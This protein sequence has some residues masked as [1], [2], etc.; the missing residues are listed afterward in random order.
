MKKSIFY[1]IAVAALA[2]SFGSCTKMKDVGVLNTGNYNDTSGPLKAASPFPI[3]FAVYNSAFQSNNMY[4]NTVIREASSIT[5]ENELKYGSVVQNNGS[6]NFTN[7][8]A[9]VNA[10]TTAGLQVFGHVLGWHEQQ[11]GTYLK[12]FAG[13]T[14]PAAT[15][16]ITNGGFENGLS[17]WS[18]FNTGNPAG[19]ATITTGSGSSEIRTGN[20]SMKVINPTAYPGSQ[21]RVQVSSASFATTVGKQ[22][23][24]SY[25]V[26]AQSPNGSIRISTGPTNAQ[27]QG[28]QTIGTNWQNVNFTFTAQIASTTFL[29]D[30]G[31][32]ANT[33][34][35]D[36][37][38]VKE[39]VQAPSG[40]NIATKLDEAL[41]NWITAA[42]TRYKGKIKAWDVVNELFAESGAVRN[43]S[44]TS[45]SANTNVLVWSNYLGRDYAL[46]AFNYAAAADPSA[47]L[48]IND[49]N[50]ES[51]RTKLDSLIAYVKEMKARGAKIDGIGTQMHM[52]VNT[53]YVDID[54]MFQKLAATGLLV[55]ISELDIRV[56]PGD[57]TGYQLI[58]TTAGIQADMYNYVI[59]SY[60]KNVPAAQRHGVTI[61]GVDDPT[62]WIVQSQK[63]VDYPLLFDANFNKKAAYSGVLR[64]LKNN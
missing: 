62:S 28:D 40:A 21:W 56:N 59:N 60:Y 14:V 13:I 33:Y 29:F 35:I 7:A 55:R 6:F 8:D 45:S 27:Y 47:L 36:D 30:M 51:N 52:S 4:R 15:E 61:W 17:G 53:R 1:I 38:S 39:V 37:V 20:G 42:V 26:K 10:A 63:K 24:I 57:K 49:F 19:S 43:N 18:T 23:T 48:F 46:K 22:Y 16:L 25:W 31:Q 9:L 5:P 3:G 34:Y 58:P 12:S 44:N 32:A 2:N 50:L 41:N 11:N 64:A 54:N